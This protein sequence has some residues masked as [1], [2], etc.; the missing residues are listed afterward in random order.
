MEK[1]KLTIDDRID[2]E[3][4]PAESTCTIKNYTGGCEMVVKYPKGWVYTRVIQHAL[5][6]AEA[7]I[8]GCRII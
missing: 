2:I 4:T 1:I 6:I 5:T 8:S 3:I 7:S